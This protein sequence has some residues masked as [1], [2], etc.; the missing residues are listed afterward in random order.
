MTV[1]PPAKALHTA[2]REALWS[3]IQSGQY[4]PQSQVPPESA[5]CAEFDVS[6]ITVRRALSDLE[7]IGAIFRIHGKGTF[8][9]GRRLVQKLTSTLGFAEAVQGPDREVHNVTLSLETVPASMLVAEQLQVGEGEQVT[10][11]QRVRQVNGEAIRLDVLYLPVAVGERLRG[12]DL[13]RRDIFPY[14]K[15]ELGLS[16]GESTLEFDSITATGDVAHQLDV[17]E[18]S[19]LLL[20][21]W[22]T[23]TMDGMPIDFARLHCR[24]GYYRHRVHIGRESGLQP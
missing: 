12:V 22:T 8:V 9:S 7:R 11:L 1:L 4:S 3:R 13:S 14:L 19:P 6:R 20:I 18:G 2:V 21:D 16:L 17:P 24:P 5:L 15:N 23:Y 10:E